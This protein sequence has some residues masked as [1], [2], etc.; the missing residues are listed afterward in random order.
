MFYAEIAALEVF[1]KLGDDARENQIL[2]VFLERR[3][4]Y[5]IH[6][7]VLEAPEW[8]VAH[9]AGIGDET[10]ASRRDVRETIANFSDRRDVM[11][12]P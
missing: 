4:V 12:A 9:R 5:Y 6:H 7:P 8:K 1:A 3:Y 2:R 10:G 11:R